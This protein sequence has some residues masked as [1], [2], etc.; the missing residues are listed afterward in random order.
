MPARGLRR[1]LWGLLLLVPLALLAVAWWYARPE[2]LSALLIGQLQ[3]RFGLTL[4]L[5][6][7][8]RIDFLPSLRVRLDAPVISAGN[9][10]QALIAADA[11]ELAVPWSM[12]FGAEPVIERIALARPRIDVDRLRD[13]ITAQAGT[14]DGAV[15]VPAFRL[16]IGDATLLRGGSVIGNGIDV[17]LDH[18]DGLAQWIGQ[19]SGGVGPESLVP[20]LQGNASA[21]VIEAGQTR[22]EGVRLRIEPATKPSG[23]P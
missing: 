7:P 11:I 19:W 9:G 22:L 17:D 15:T 20:P 12:L 5:A 16:E 13:W 18:V 23:Q 4:A 6:K 8:A 3:S 14:G 10:G 21:D 2:R 1:L